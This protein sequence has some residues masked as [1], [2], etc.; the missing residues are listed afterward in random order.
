MF[1]YQVPNVSSATVIKRPSKTCKTPYVADVQL[2]NDEATHMA[3]TACLGCGGLVDAGK[4]IVMKEVSNTKNVCKYRVSFAKVQER[5]MEHIVG[6]DPKLA[7]DMVEVALQ[8]NYIST[9]KDVKEYQREKK[10]LNSRFDYCGVDAN[11]VP[12]IMEVKN[13]PLADYVDCLAKEKKKD[14]TF[15]IE[16]CV[17]KSHTFPMAIGKSKQIP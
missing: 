14:W 12:F 4:E 8:K 15:V 11:N 7:E 2:E 9:L 17:A 6:V 13:V 10:F 16:T 3:H 1:L 5:G